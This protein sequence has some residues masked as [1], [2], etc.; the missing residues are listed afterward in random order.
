MKKEIMA[1]DIMPAGKTAA[2]AS[3]EYQDKNILSTNCIMLWLE[4][5]IISGTAILISWRA[6][7]GS[8]FFLTR[9]MLMILS[10]K[11]LPRNTTKNL[12]D[13]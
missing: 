4:V 11:K 12:P 13:P 7:P 8:S 9:K 5:E 10:I 1:K 6:E 2:S 3:A